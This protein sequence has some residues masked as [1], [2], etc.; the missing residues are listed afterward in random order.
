[1]IADGKIALEGD[2]LTTDDEGG[3]IEPSTEANPEAPA[4]GIPPKE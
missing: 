1:V 3:A 4:N 2:P